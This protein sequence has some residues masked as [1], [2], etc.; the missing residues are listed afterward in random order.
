MADKPFPQAVHVQ[1]EGDNHPFAHV[2]V[3]A[4]E[5][6]QIR[7]RHPRFPVR[8]CEQNDDKRDVRGKRAYMVFVPLT[9]LITRI[10]SGLSE[11]LKP[12]IG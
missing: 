6:V 7:P 1:A 12:E 4:S 11:S 3:V 10:C 8:I 9:N 5:L 2:R